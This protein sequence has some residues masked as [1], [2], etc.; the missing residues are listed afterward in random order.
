MILAV[1]ALAGAATLAEAIQA[2]DRA[3]VARLIKQREGVNQAEADGSTP[4]HW[5]VR[6]DDAA[7]VSLLLK[8]GANAS[9]ANRLG[10]TPLALARQPNPD[11]SI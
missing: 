4:L 3:T 5:A 6:N 2:G 1:S 11:A 7:T 8:A 10:V 9:A